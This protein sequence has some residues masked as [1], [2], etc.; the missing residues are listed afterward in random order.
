MYWPG[1]LLG[2]ASV[3][4]GK[5]QARGSSIWLCLTGVSYDP[6][7]ATMDSMRTFSWLKS[8]RRLSPQI[9]FSLSAAALGIYLNGFS[10]FKDRHAQNMY[11]YLIEILYGTFQLD[12]K[13]PRTISDNRNKSKILPILILSRTYVSCPTKVS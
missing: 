9:Q 7:K 10:Y 2:R 8:Y 13:L 11:V 1:Q 12:K 4:S 6:P 3:L 5:L